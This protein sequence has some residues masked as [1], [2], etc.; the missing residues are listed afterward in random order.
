M[1]PK[2]LFNSF[3]VTGNN[4]LP[5]NGRERHLASI[6]FPVALEAVSRKWEDIRRQEPLEAPNLPRPPATDDFDVKVEAT[7]Q[8]LAI[9]LD[10]STKFI[11]PD[12]SLGHLFR[13]FG[14]YECKTLATWRP[15]ET[16]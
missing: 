14:K 15:L 4:N 10:S 16:R 2:D 12:P 1:D 11:R 13:T 6:V 5:L 9:I 8:N 7:R 3:F